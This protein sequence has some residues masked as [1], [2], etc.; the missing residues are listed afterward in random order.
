MVSEMV[1]QLAIPYADDLA[2]TQSMKEIAAVKVPGRVPLEKLLRRQYKRA[3]GMGEAS[4]AAEHKA[5]ETDPEYEDKFNA[6]VEEVAE[7]NPTAFAAVQEAI[8]LATVN[9]KAGLPTDPLDPIGDLDVED[10]IGGAARTTVDAILGTVKSA[11]TSAAQRGLPTGGAPAASIVANIATV[12]TPRQMSLKTREDVNGAY[13]TGRVVRRKIDKVLLVTY[14]LTPQLGGPNGM[15]H[16]PCDSC[17]ATASRD[18]NPFLSN[19]PVAVEFQTP[20]PDCASTASGANYC[21]C[22]LIGMPIPGG[23]P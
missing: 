4:A 1:S 3:L 19:S 7:S 10:Y 6:A 8:A 5:M 16:D 22:D 18:D 17:V 11:G 21:L 9:K 14:T 15:G 2:A 20:N 13:A 23:T 12:T